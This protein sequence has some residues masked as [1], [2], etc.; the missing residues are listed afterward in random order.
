MRRQPIIHRFRRLTECGRVKTLP[1][2]ELPDARL[3]P[4]RARRRRVEFPDPNSSGELPKNQLEHL[5]VSDSQLQAAENPCPHLLPNDGSGMTQ[6]QLQQLSGD[7]AKFAR[8][9]RSHGVSNWPDPTVDSSG[10]LEYNL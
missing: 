10:R 6:A 9:M 7:M 5:G 3:V 4:L 1:V 8:C 2:T